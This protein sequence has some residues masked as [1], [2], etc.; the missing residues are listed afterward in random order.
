MACLFVIG[1]AAQAAP[2]E[3]TT[4]QGRL[5]NSAGD[6]LPGPVDIQIAIWDQLIGGGTPLYWETHSGVPLVDGVFN[7]L[8]GTG[9]VMLGSFDADLF[10]AQNRYLEVIVNSEALTPRQPFSSVAYALQSGESDA[11]TYAA[12]AGDA[13]TVDGSHAA[14]L[15][16]SAHVSDTGNPHGV[17]AAQVGAA[18]SADL[19]AHESDASAHHTRYADGE[20]VSAVLA[21]DGPGSG[22][23]AD[24]LDG[25]HASSFAEAGHNHDTQYY[26]QAQVDAIV[27]S[28]QVQIDALT[29]LTEHLSRS[30]NDLY[31][32]GANLHIVDGSGDTYGPVN[33]LG[34]LIV[35]YNHPRGMGKDDRSGSHNIVVGDYQN[36]ASYGGL[37]AGYWNSINGTF[38]SVTGGGNNTASGDRASVSGGI[39]N[40][41]SGFGASVSGGQ[42]N[43][44]S[45]SSTSV[46]GGQG[47]TASND[48]SS[49]S[50]GQGNTASGW[51]ASV[52]GG[53]TNTAD[54]QGASISG[55]EDNTASGNR[56]SVSGGEYNTAS[57]NF[58]H[59]SGGRNNKASGD[60]A[61]VVGGGS[62]NSLYGNEAFGN[63]SAVLGGIFNIA[64]DPNRIYHSI[65]QK[66]TVSGGDTNR[67]TGT[68]SSVVGG[69]TNTASGDVSTVTGG[70]YNEAS[71]GFSFVGGGGGENSEDGNIAFAHYSAILG[72]LNN[73]TGD[74]SCP[75]DD[76]LSRYVC[77]GGSDHNIGPQ[78]TV[79]GGTG[80]TASGDFASVSGGAHVTASG[81]NSSVSGGAHNTAS[82]DG[83][84]VSGG[85]ENTAAGV[86]STVSG[87]YD[88]S[89]SDI[90][91]WR[92]GSYSSDF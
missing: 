24:L 87:G 89:V 30:G 3:D 60:F 38:S 2:P 17:T 83:S 22:L 67:A 61:A 6:P 31:V 64:G 20:A 82:S 81:E 49:V 15:D 92:G 46:S 74:G 1:G 59:V 76:V 13:D 71:G 25:Q 5:L 26:T 29:S 75:W 73:L 55:G 32:T 8:L 84:S 70:R 44:A 35:G 34:N 80:N 62:D 56:A 78:A 11:A 23:D 48:Y 79:S 66:S 42:D 53:W 40:T 28:L 36:Y 43:T 57:G 16:Q 12:T 69:K 51:G 10:A 58:A 86:F 7:L 90:Y 14:S 72:G 47:N 4:Y 41:A 77:T 65:G 33:G 45:E 37:I 27:A 21:G 68:Y 85:W 63:Y 91:D 54:G 52:S 9:T 18:T 39:A 88:R 19:T 50:G